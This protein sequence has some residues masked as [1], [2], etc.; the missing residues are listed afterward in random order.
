MN[1][2]PFADTQDRPLTRWIIAAAIT[3]LIPAALLVAFLV[4]SLLFTGAQVIESRS[5]VWRPVVPW[6]LFTVTPWITVSLAIGGLIVAVGYAR[7]IGIARAMGLIPLL[8]WSLAA[9]GSTWFFGAVLPEALLGSEPLLGRSD[10]YLAFAVNLLAAAV[11]AIRL[12]MVG[13]AHDRLRASRLL[14][15]GFLLLPTGLDENAPFTIEAPVRWR[16][17]GREL[18]P[19]GHETAADS[20]LS[21]RVL[22]A[23]RGAAESGEPVSLPG[24]AS[25]RRAEHQESDGSVEVSYLYARD[26][27]PRQRARLH[28]VIRPALLRSSAE[29]EVLLRSADVIAGSF[30]WR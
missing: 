17:V 29:T 16:V 12:G 21:L 6:P 23:E 8:G 2:S 9:A 19:L 30:R 11:L 18:L 3:L 24:G 13:P 1:T 22:T 20:P 5:P 28:A 7:S 25:V 15:D 4:G 26:D 10:H 27:A 14:A